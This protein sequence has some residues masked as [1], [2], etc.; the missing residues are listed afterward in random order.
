MAELLT[1]N[2][3]LQSVHGNNS[4]KKQ[5]REEKNVESDSRVDEMKATF[6]TKLVIQ[7]ELHEVIMM[8]RPKNPKITLKS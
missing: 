7:S 6:L 2:A 5:T 3:A 4:S 8:R 1:R